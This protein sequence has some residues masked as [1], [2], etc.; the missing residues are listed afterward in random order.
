MPTGALTVLFL[1]DRNAASSLIAEAVL[2]VEGNG[3]FRACSAGLAPA[4]DVDADVVNFLAT[5][6]V[7]VSG[8]RPKGVRELETLYPDGFHFVIT[9]SRAAASF[10]DGHAWRGDPVTADWTLDAEP[11]EAEAEASSG[12]I[13]DAFWTLSRRIRIFASLPHRKATR[14]SLQNKLYA[15]QTV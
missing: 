8:L 10:A 9:L 1:S 13:R 11:R 14:H 2:R 15:L 6:H 4:S 7:P 5:R 12:A 3:R